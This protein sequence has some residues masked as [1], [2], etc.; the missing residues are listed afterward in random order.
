MSH[1][2]R[3]GTLLGPLRKAATLLGFLRKAATVASFSVQVPQREW[4]VP[5]IRTRRP[6]I[7]SAGGLKKGVQCTAKLSRDGLSQNGYGV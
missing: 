2:R 7:V 4:K 5:W 6:H 1:L 3:A